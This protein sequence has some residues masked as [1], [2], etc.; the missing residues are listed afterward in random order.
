[1]I[2]RTGSRRF[3]PDQPRTEPIAHHLPAP[4]AGGPTAKMRFPSIHPFLLLATLATV[5]LPT[6]AENVLRSTSLNACQSNSLFTARKFNVTFSPDTLKVHIDMYAILSIEGY[7][8]LDITLLA[9]GYKAMHIEFDPCK[10]GL[11]GLCPMTSGKMD[12]PF[13]LDIPKS[14]LDSIPGIAYTFPDLDA[15]IKILANMTSGDQAGQTVACLEAEFSNGK[16]GTFTLKDEVLGFRQ[17]VAFADP[18]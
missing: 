15:T 17:V 8:L 7:V 12:D 16:T 9:Y 18:T 5:V 14:A 1:M 10:Y 4:E 2:N 3:T 6:A 13:N 11:M